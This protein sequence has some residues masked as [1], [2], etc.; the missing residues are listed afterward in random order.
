MI[1]STRS[2]KKETAKHVFDLEKDIEKKK[3]DDRQR[4][5]F[6]RERDE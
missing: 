3:K 1:D 2:T 4:A 6:Q 5:Q